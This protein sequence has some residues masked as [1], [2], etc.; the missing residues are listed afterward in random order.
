VRLDH[1]GGSARLEIWPR[2]PHV[3]HPFAPMLP[4]ARRAIGH[5]SSFLH[6]RW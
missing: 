3:W 4:E 5:I 2:I 6:E 1:V